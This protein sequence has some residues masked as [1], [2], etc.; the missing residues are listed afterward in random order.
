MPFTRSLLCATFFSVCSALFEQNC[1]KTESNLAQT[2]R[3]KK[4]FKRTNSVTNALLYEITICYLF[5]I[6]SQQKKVMFI[7]WNSFWFDFCSVFKHSIHYLHKS[8]TVFTMSK[9][10]VKESRKKTK[11]QL[12]F[13]RIY[14]AEK[15]KNIYNYWSKHLAH[16]HAQKDPPHSFNKKS[17]CMVKRCFIKG[18]LLLFS[19][20]CSAC[21][22][23]V[24]IWHKDQIL[25]L[26]CLPSLLHPLIID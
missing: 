16:T 23:E 1:I 3:F 13:H 20:W 7:L 12:H 26:Y 22:T 4:P 21:V 25:H 15:W 19:Q 17:G 10:E 18:D 2:I 11:Q 24:R 14:P 8:T 9:A 6:F 5:V